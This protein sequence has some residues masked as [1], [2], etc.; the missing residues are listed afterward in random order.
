M[1]TGEARC[2]PTDMAPADSPASVTR[3]GSPPKK[4]M[5]ALTHSIAAI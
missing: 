3:L 5:L 2:M 1:L 4:A